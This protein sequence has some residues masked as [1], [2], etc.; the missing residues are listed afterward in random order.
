MTPRVFICHASEDKARFVTG[1]AE[2]LTEKGIDVWIDL[3]EIYP[4]DSLVDKIFNEGIKTADAVII[5]LSKNS[6]EKPWVLEELNAA[7]VKRIEEKTKLIP[8][9][10]DRCEVPGCLKST[11]WI[12]IAN[13]ENYSEELSRIVVSIYGQKGKPPLGKKPKYTQISADHLPGLT[14]I[15]SIVFKLIYDYAIEIGQPSVASKDIIGRINAFDIDNLLFIESL[16]ILDDYHF[17]KAERTLGGN[18]P[19]IRTTITGFELYAKNF[20]KNYPDMVSV[21]KQKIVN[22]DMKNSRQISEASTIP[23]IIVDYILDI[24]TVKGFIKTQKSGLTTMIASVSPK[25]R[26]T[27]L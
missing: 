7:F 20:I 10:I 24:L 19:F 13:L 23:P 15:D 1:L 26:R 17:L 11:V 21:V 12:S 8:I 22:E 2:K 27:M 3:W 16:E 14:E 6:V 9:I 18:I 5:V 25:L 4:G